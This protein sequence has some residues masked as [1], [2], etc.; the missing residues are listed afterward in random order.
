[1]DAIQYFEAEWCWR[2]LLDE[3]IPPEQSVGHRRHFL[4]G[5]SIV[6]DSTKTAVNHSKTHDYLPHSS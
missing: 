4:F 5:S 6:T 2:Y 3:W 1:M